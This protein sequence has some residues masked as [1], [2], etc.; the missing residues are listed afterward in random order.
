MGG[1]GG[2]A[3]ASPSACTRPG[4]HVRE[5]PLVGWKRWACHLPPAGMQVPPTPTRDHHGALRPVPPVNDVEIVGS[6]SG[7][8]F[9]RD[10]PDVVTPELSQPHPGQL[11]ARRRCAV[12]GGQAA[13]AAHA[14]R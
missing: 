6:H 8:D 12:A 3:G 13:D 14:V 4:D 1:F 5:P 11:H 9:N 7:M 2:Q 10:V